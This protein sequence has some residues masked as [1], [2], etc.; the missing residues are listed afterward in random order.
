[1]IYCSR[2]YSTSL[3]EKL[4]Y[5]SGVMPPNQHYVEV[6]VPAG[7]SY[8]FFDV[9]DPANR[10]WDDPSPSLSKDYGDDWTMS[11]R[12]LLLIVPSVVARVDENVLINPAHAEFRTVGPALFNRPVH[13]DKRLFGLVSASP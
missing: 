4:V 11:L 3:L 1:M 2:R 9:N 10:G 12:S 8:E 13:W 6:A 5:S 7:V